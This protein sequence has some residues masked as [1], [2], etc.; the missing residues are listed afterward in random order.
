MIT[1]AVHTVAPGISLH[2]RVAGP[3][4]A[5]TLLFLHGFPEGAFVWDALLTHFSLPENGGY[6]CVAPWLRGFGPSSAP[7][8]AR[9]YRPK[10]L[11]QDILGIIQAESPGAPVAA[12]VAHDWGGAVAWN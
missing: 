1:T 3:P 4:G 10:P 6:R 5:P 2:C 7:A 8:D 9:D 11:V 12:L